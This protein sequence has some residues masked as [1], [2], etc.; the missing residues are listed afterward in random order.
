MSK[1]GTNIHLFTKTAISQVKE[2][3]RIWKRREKGKGRRK[4]RREGRREEKSM[5]PSFP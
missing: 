4:K 2:K 1:Y 5:I 3:K